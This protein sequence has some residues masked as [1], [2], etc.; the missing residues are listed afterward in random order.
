MTTKTFPLLLTSFAYI[1]EIT[2]FGVP[3]IS[4]IDPLALGFA[5]LLL[6][7]SHAIVD[8]AMFPLLFLPSFHFGR[9]LAV[10]VFIVALSLGSTFLCVCVCALVL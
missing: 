1:C 6:F 4:C 9:Y 10:V 8:N 3:N 5:F 2:A 7:F